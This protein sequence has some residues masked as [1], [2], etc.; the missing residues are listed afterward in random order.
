MQP[1]PH[2]H[3]SCTSGPRVSTRRRSGFS[4]LELMLVLGILG[5]LMAVAAVNVL[6][7]Q[8][9]AN[10]RATEATMRT[11]QNGI[12]EYKTFA[13]TF[14][15][16]IADLVPNYVSTV[17]DA[18]GN[19]LYYATPGFAGKP[20]TLISNGP[21]GEPETDDDMDLWTIIEDNAETPDG[22]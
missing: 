19:D 13:N 1:L 15:V 11:V 5:V 20:F 16:N 2:I 21:D 14:P 22:A 4:L 6:G 18:W 8:D 9:R 10:I 3:A 12:I 17:K 7:G